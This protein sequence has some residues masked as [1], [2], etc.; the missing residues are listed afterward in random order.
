MLTSLGV[1][2]NYVSLDIEL[3]TVTVFVLDYTTWQMRPDTGLPFGYYGYW[4]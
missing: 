2:G 4:N 1:R 3:D